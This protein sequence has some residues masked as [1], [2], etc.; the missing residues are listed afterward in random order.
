ME[1]GPWRIK[2][3]EAEDYVHK[4]NGKPF[5]EEKKWYKI[6]NITTA[7]STV[8]VYHVTRQNLESVYAPIPTINTKVRSGS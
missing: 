7:E 3:T 4:C 5:H 6:I 1:L 8:N 2:N